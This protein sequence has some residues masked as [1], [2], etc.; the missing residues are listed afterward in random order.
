[1]ADNHTIGDFST[2]TNV[3]TTT[4]DTDAPTRS[5]GATANV[6]ESSMVSATYRGSAGAT[7]ES[8]EAYLYTAA[9][10][11]EMGVLARK[12]PQDA[13]PAAE[14]NILADATGSG[15]V[16]MNLMQGAFVMS[17][18]DFTGASTA[19]FT[20]ANAPAAIQPRKWLKVT[21]GGT[22]GYIPWFST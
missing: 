16:S 19:T 9:Q 20:A 21:I 18:F 10:Q 5:V 14:L 22:V 1:M 6:G 4:L 17:G 11:A 15:V 12:Q 7:Q 8:A 2:N 13:N 3:G